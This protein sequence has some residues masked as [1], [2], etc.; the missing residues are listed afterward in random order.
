MPNQFTM[1]DPPVMTDQIYYLG[2]GVKNFEVGEFSHT[3]A[4]HADCESKLDKVYTTVVTN[5]IDGDGTVSVL[6][7]QRGISVDANVLPTATEFTLTVTL[8]I[9]AM[10]VELGTSSMSFKVTMFDC[11]EQESVTYTPLPLGGTNVDI[12]YLIKTPS[13]AQEW[14]YPIHRLHPDKDCGVFENEAGM[15][16]SGL[17]ETLHASLSWFSSTFRTVTALDEVQV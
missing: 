8:T 16:D 13:V 7:S 17:V 14:V 4:I 1:G 6:P 3:T 12:T 10:G 11:I 15:I 5:L 9:S 2:S